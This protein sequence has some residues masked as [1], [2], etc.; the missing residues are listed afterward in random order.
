M[1]Q[2]REV[3]RDVRR[4]RMHCNKCK[5]YYILM[6]YDDI[7]WHWNM[8]CWIF[9]MPLCKLFLIEFSDIQS[10]LI[11][12]TIMCK[13]VYECAVKQ[14]PKML[15]MKYEISIWLCIICIYYITQYTQIE[16]SFLYRDTQCGVTILVSIWEIS[17]AESF[18]KTH[19]YIV[20]QWKRNKVYF[21]HILILDDIITQSASFSILCDESQCID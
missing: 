19:I 21:I 10:C 5:L 16:P 9:Y 11:S 3:P 20:S 13:W 12:L 2:N 7:D 17:R 1:K 14:L 18:S 6:F 8:I 15:E 4:A